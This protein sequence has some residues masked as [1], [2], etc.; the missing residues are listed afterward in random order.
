MSVK[1][2]PGVNLTNILQAA[3][4]MKVFGAPFMFLELGFVILGAWGLST[5]VLEFSNFKF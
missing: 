4:C 3:F 1:W 5:P 2:T